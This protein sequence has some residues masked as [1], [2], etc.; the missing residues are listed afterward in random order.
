MTPEALKAQLER[1]LAELAPPEAVASRKQAAL[2]A[3]NSVGF[4]TRKHEQWKYTDVRALAEGEFDLTWPAPDAE[5]EQAAAA[6]IAQAG[7]GT[8]P[9]YVFV[10]G[11]FSAALSSAEMPVGVTLEPEA[12][13]RRRTGV[14]A[15]SPL[16]TLNAAFTHR[17][18]TLR[19]ADK[20]HVA[21]PVELVFVG[22]PRAGIA[23]QLRL[24]VELG[25]QSEL[26]L[27]QHFIDCDAAG[28]DDTGTWLNA[29]VDIIQQPASRLTLYRLQNHAHDR[30]QTSLLEADLARD[31]HIAAGY[32]EVGGRLVRN[33]INVTLNEA[34]ASADL[35]GV[36]LGTGDRVLDNHVRVDHAAPYT[37]ST[38]TFRAIVDDKSRA[39]FN[40]KVIVRQDAQH[41]DSRQSSDN[42][43]LSKRAEVD[44]KPELEIYADD[45]KCAH[46]ATVGE[47]DEQQMLYLRTRGIDALTAR[48]LLTFAFANTVLEKIGLDSM[49]DAAAGH[50]GGVLPHRERWEELA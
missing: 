48:A 4:P 32:V 29:V 28:D 43:L 7:I 13:V 37:T 11:H 31:A 44:T 9:R 47:L 8:G 34:G 22:S 12:E 19:V 40:G 27:V 30:Y 3:F 36:T 20:A 41:I 2:E 10:D 35:F 45:V 42:L 1:Q 15:A 23:P 26:T 25:A 38:Q 46:G 5:A 14:D 39:V 21:E 49:R 33:D 16:A 6:R 50:V 17:G 18:A 24:A